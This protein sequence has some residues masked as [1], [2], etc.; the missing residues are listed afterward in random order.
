MSAVA[1]ETLSNIRTVR[2]FS[3]EEGE[4]KRFEA[5]NR[6]V[7][8]VGRKRTIY[9]ATYEFLLTI[10]LYGSMGAVMFCAVRLYLNDTL[11]IG[12]IAT[13]LLYLGLFTLYFAW[14]T[15]VLGTLASVFGAADK[16]VEMMNYKPAIK[17]TGGD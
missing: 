2:A 14:I 17:T 6:E 5:G 7:Y 15:I 4:I 1:G 12:S 13:F 9:T 11:S 8:R 16:I 10:L 3:N